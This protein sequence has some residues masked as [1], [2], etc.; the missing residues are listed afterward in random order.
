M[1]D[2]ELEDEHCSGCGLVI[3]EGNVITFDDNVWHVK[4]FRCSSCH[5]SFQTNSNI[6]ILNEQPVCESCSYTC[7]VCKNHIHDQAILIGDKEV[8]AFHQ[9]CF[10][11]YSCHQP[12][13]PNEYTSTNKGFQCSQCHSSDSLLSEEISPEIST[14][15]ESLS[16]DDVEF[17]PPI[18]N[19]IETNTSPLI[20]GRP[21]I[22]PPTR[23]SSI[24]KRPTRSHSLRT[25]TE[26]KSKFKKR[27]SMMPPRSHSDLGLEGIHGPP[28]LPP[29]PFVD[30]AI[31]EENINQIIEGVRQTQLNSVE[32]PSLSSSVTDEEKSS[33]D[34]TDIGTDVI[35]TSDIVESSPLD[36][37]SE[38]ISLKAL[39]RQLVEQLENVREDLLKE[40]K[41]RQDIEEK[42]KVLEVER[43]LLLQSHE[44]YTNQ[45]KEAVNM[46]KILSDNIE[47]LSVQ[48]EEM[49]TIIHEL[50]LQ[51][52]SLYLEIDSMSKKK[53][54]ELDS[55]SISDE[56]KRESFMILSNG[57]QDSNYANF[58]NP[59]VVEPLSPSFNY[60]LEK[61]NDEKLR[62]RSAVVN[63]YKDTDLSQS[64]AIS[65]EES[66]F[67]SMNESEYQ[68][69]TPYNNA[70]EV[71]A[72]SK[73]DG[74][75]ES[76]KF[77]W[78]GGSSFKSKGKSTSA[79][80]SNER[81]PEPDNTP[82]ASNSKIKYKKS[83]SSSLLTNKSH[84]FIIHTFIRP[85]KCDHC[86]EKMWGLQNKEM[87]CQ[88]CGFHS[89]IKCSN[90]AAQDCPGHI[91]TEKE[92][93][94][95]VVNMF[96]NELEEQ[97]RFEGRDIPLIVELC[98]DAVEKRGIMLEGI[99]RKSGPTSQMRDIQS[100]L[101]RAANGEGPPPNLED[102]E[103]FSDI[104]AVTSVVKQYFREL[105]V[106]LL[107]YDLYKDFMDALY[108]DVEEERLAQFKSIISQLPKANYDTLKYLIMH[109]IRVQEYESVNLMGTK[110]LA[111]VFGPTLMR[112]LDPSQE[113]YDTARK[114]AVVE[115]LLCCAEDLF[116]EEYQISPTITFD[117]PE[118]YESELVT[119]EHD[120]IDLATDYGD[121]TKIY[122]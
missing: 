120:L 6:L 56:K 77:K 106:P 24:T 108:I 115:Y 8:Q 32:D 53:Q 17:I 80:N 109:L 84:T 72:S 46:Y 60:P 52:E 20:P 75:K 44:E 112:S 76:K 99:Y 97:L 31:L 102:P 94:G 23:S 121:N 42:Y 21:H 40:A 81:E 92:A 2:Y 30:D 83:N 16:Q 36:I 15:M 71:P 33:E 9:R 78:M 66:E 89:H 64:L 87:R 59:L 68:N 58:N 57:Y 67:P 11:C 12:L 73:A 48:K 101:A 50:Q 55:L 113:F 39:N 91:Q 4:C 61:P 96:G 34:N 3:N 69:T 10:K 28:T 43:D 38:V 74:K 29:L 85:L 117:Y 90:L 25:P 95:G 111:V 5:A 93:S 122:T 14:D 79:P 45:K 62:R 18:A 88:L 41:S 105:P 104:T 54:I 103:E 27:Q 22:E 116:E 65:Y 86:G 82:P 1:A 47:H 107:T 37:S 51:K 110:N 118:Q 35:E 26:Q 70:L 49:E 119:Q 114:N 19:P 13:E 100:A 98:I 63:Q 7:E